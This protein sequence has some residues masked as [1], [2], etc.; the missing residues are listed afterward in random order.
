MCDR[1]CC[2][3]KCCPDQIND[4]L[5]KKLECIWKNKFCD[6]TLIN[7]V[8]YP[9]NCVIF[10]THTIKKCKSKINGLNTKSPLV[11]NGFYTAE[12]TECK[13]LNLYEAKIPDIPGKCGCKSSG[14]IYIESL[15]K[16]GISIENDDYN[17][18]G[19][20][21]RYLNIRSKAIGMDP[22]DFSKKTNSCT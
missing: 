9:N 5:V 12:F 2:E 16:M 14:E 21:P 19:E 15:S 18:K 8:G 3:K 13:W 17:W 20:T 1:C 4:C 10:I 7:K 22:T 6:A 11:N